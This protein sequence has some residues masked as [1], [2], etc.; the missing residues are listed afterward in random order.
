MNT[1][2]NLL[3]LV[4]VG[5]AQAVVLAGA[6]TI[7]QAMTRDYEALVHD[8]GNAATAAVAARAIDDLLWSDHVAQVAALAGD[9][10]DDL[11]DLVASRADAPLRAALADVRRRGAVSGGTVALWGIE[12][13]ALD[14][15][16][17][18]ALWHGPA[19]DEAEG[20][21]APPGAAGLQERL[22]A[23]TGTERLSLL[24]H[25]WLQDGHPVLSVALPTGGLRPTGFVVLHVDALHA[26]G[27]LH[28]RSGTAVRIR[29]IGDDRVLFEAGFG[30]AQADRLETTVLALASTDGA[31][32]A[33]VELVR[34]VTSLDTA[35][36]AT[37]EQ[38]LA[39]FVAVAGGLAL[40][41]LGAYLFAAAR[42][43]AA[44]A[45]RLVAAQD[46]EAAAARA[47]AD[48]VAARADEERRAAIAQATTSQRVVQT[49]SDGIA[50]LATG[51]LRSGLGGAQGADLPPEYGALWRLFDDLRLRLGEMIGDLARTGGE[52]NGHAGQIAGLSTDLGQRTAAQAGA[53]ETSARALAQLTD[54]VRGTADQAEAADQAMRRNRC[55]ADA[56]GRSV[57][58]AVEAMARIEEASAQISRIVA[59]IEEIA[60][61]TNL[62]ALNA[63]VE[64]A[65]AGDAG[66]GFAVVASEVR[67][68]AQRTADA[69][70]EVRQLVA[71]SKAQ[72]ETGS[73][74]VRA[75]G[76]EIDAVLLSLGEASDL[77]AEIAATASR[78]A[79]GLG[80]INQAIADLDRAVQANRTI[81]ED[82][83]RAGQ[84]V[85]AHAGALDTA[86]SRFRLPPAAEMRRSRPP[87]AA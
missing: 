26:L 18:A 53:L 43:E 70:A 6:L 51:D 79:S 27:L 4:G 34:D 39:R 20:T 46:A 74:L 2:R 33:R 58:V 87:E 81:A 36:A 24:V 37:R 15:E 8:Y 17:R 73:E 61:Q 14:L 32:L 41:T 1:G 7:G 45:A 84:G 75:T 57:H 38:A 23:R 47:R 35:L 52:L 49:M 86:L 30:S 71:D 83:A 40:A 21:L 80:E 82:A 3:L 77:V 65:R 67:S 28:M 54:T 85:L 11:R 12:V 60:F 69:A 64:A 31:P 5:L 13:L 9:V 29:A 62:L 63:G 55:A 56:G 16:R 78:Q 19:G 44:L 25:G 76:H 50:R 42:R 66:R 72:V 48:A 68:L 22:A 10:A 59:V